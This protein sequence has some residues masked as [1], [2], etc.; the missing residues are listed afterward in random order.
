MTSPVSL[1]PGVTIVWNL[2]ALAALR[3]DP[4]LLN[5]IVDMT[6]PVVAGAR[7]DAPKRTGAGARSIRSEF[8]LDGTEPTVRIS[9]DQD[10]Y[11]LRF[12][13]LGTRYL[14]ARPFLVPALD[15]YL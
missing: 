7:A 8:E 14:P 10:H 15:R 11:Y 6:K 4:V 5:E 3:Y 2:A 12:H 9:W 13:E 1:G